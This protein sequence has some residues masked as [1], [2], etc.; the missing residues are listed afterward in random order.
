MKKIVCFGLILFIFSLMPVGAVGT[1]AK[2][3]AVIN[4]DTG[5]VIY[6]QNA[7][8]KLPMAS[9]TKIMTALLLCENAD[10]NKE[11]T[12]TADMLRVEGSSMGLLAGDRV[13][14]HDLLYGMMLASGNDAA[15]VTA[16]SLGGTVEKFAD[17]MN[18][19]AEELGLCNT[20]FVTPSGLDADGHY[21][22]ARELALLAAYALKNEE[23]AKAASSESAVLNYGNPPYRRSLT[24]HNKMLKLFD[25]AVGVKTGFTK[26]SGRCLVSAARKD[27]KLAVAVTLNDPDDWNDHANLLNYGLDKIKQTNY[28][29]K[30]SCY[31]IP[32]VGSEA[33]QIE[34]FI[35]PYT[36]NTLETENISCQVYLPKF[37]YAPIVKGDVLGTV[38][39]KMG[40]EVI[41][42]VEL[43]SLRNIP[44][45][46]DKISFNEIIRKN[47]KYI[48]KCI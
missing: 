34:V 33:E 24:N 6:A 17:M 21:T 4:G 15:N 5:E 13:T 45:L 27:G 35:E 28:S 18:K 10:L 1:S 20:H 42:T 38:E 48:L 19:K 37:L 44:A 14:Y 8:E 26:K 30:I 39:Y 46:P 25:G 9:T 16:I 2:A 36:I 7:D 41:G 3:A 22:T 40:D 43:T 12:V 32:V 11:I 31:N 47:I 23:F 29:P